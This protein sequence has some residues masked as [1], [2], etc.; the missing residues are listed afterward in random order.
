VEN[1][2]RSP[3]SAGKG[4]GLALALA[5]L[6]APIPSAQAEDALPR[7]KNSV[8]L[9]SPLV[10]AVRDEVK[11]EGR[12]GSPAQT[13]T[14]TAA[15]YGLFMMY[16]NPRIVLNNTFFNTDVNHSKVWGNIATL[17][18]YGDP[19]AKA[20]WYLGTS[21]MWHEID[22]ETADIRV[23][24]PLAKAGL[25]FRVP[26]WHLSINPYVGYGWQS[27]ETAIS[28]P[29]MS[30]E[31]TENTGAMIYGVLAQ[32][33]W[34]M[35]AAYAKYYLED[36]LDRNEQY[37]VFRFWATSMFSKHAGMLARFEYSEQVGSTDVSALFGPVFYF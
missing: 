22:G 36:N 7:E 34:R 18:L 4:P 28:A 12:P 23:S 3:S 15:E 14:D 20:T 9:V 33:R 37:N 8:F 16:A 1:Q 17:G 10:G 24:E 19:T 32:W 31:Q 26:T 21:Y 6:L 25:L 27:V 35:L 11:V 5:F 29:G 2:I 30:L 13:L